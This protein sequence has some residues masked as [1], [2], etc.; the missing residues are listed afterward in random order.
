MTSI[1]DT[2][3]YRDAC[4]AAA[5]HM[6]AFEHFRRDQTLNKIWEHVTEVEGQRYLDLLTDRASILLQKARDE[7]WDKRLGNPHVY[8]YGKWGVWSPTTLRYLFVLSDVYA[9]FP[10]LGPCPRILEIGGGYGGL[11][12][13]F[14]KF[15]PKCGYTI[16]DLAETCELQKKYAHM[17]ATPFACFDYTIYLSQRI[18][19]DQPFDLVISNY[20]FSECTRPIQEI[21]RT[22][23]FPRCTHGYFTCNFEVQNWVYRQGEEVARSVEM[24]RMSRAE[25]LA[26]RKG[27][28]VRPHE[29]D[30]GHDLYLWT[31]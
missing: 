17:N 23:V 12:I 7:Q 21:Y 3:E 8:D 22:R 20:A 18:W 1:S 5:T 16:I 26:S 13:M 28:E 27:S 29:P 9:K 30:M 15:M 31:W 6:E 19:Y 14:K 4:K 2:A 10:W 11:A 25:M 24:P